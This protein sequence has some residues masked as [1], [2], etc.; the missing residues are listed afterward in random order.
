[1]PSFLFPTRYK[2][3]FIEMLLLL[4]LKLLLGSSA[5][6]VAVFCWLAFVGAGDG[7]GAA[8]SIAVAAVATDERFCALSDTVN[9]SCD[10]NDVR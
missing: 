10:I 5:D 2:S 1:M 7:I 6:P 3:L 4:L 8:P 9:I